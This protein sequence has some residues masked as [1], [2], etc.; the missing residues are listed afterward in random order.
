MMLPV[1]NRH[2]LIQDQHALL[3]LPTLCAQQ[4]DD[5]DG[6]ETKLLNVPLSSLVSFSFPLVPGS[7][8]KEI[9]SLSG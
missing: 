1:R 5:L 4:S 3:H 2:L 9:Y 7:F 6:T 8:K